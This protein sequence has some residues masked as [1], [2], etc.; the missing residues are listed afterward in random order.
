MPH[1]R[2]S[3]HSI[4]SVSLQTYTQKY[5]TVRTFRVAVRRT[6]QPRFTFCAGPVILSLLGPAALAV[7]LIAV[8]C[9]NRLSGGC[10]TLTRPPSYSG[11]VDIARRH[12]PATVTQVRFELGWLGAVI[13]LQYSAALVFTALYLMAF[14]CA[15]GMSRWD[16]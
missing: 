13:F 12:N 10:I 7:L 6:L 5:T 14:K 4:I 9:V 1:L 16:L 15:A 3:L 8:T 11:I 2:S